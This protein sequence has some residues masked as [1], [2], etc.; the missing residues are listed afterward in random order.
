MYCKRL[1]GWEGSV[2]RYNFCI[3][4]EAAGLG[5]RNCI[6]IQNCIVTR[7]AGAGQGAGH[8]AGSAGGGAAGGRAQADVR[9]RADSRGARGAR[10]GRWASGLGVLLGYGLCTWC[11]QPVFDPV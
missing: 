11:T 6:A 5:W 8:G 3:V 9:A 4:T 10:H 7:G 1:D 2:S